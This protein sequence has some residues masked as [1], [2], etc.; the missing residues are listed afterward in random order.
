MSGWGR[1][2]AE[3]PIRVTHPSQCR[4]VHLA[5][6]VRRLHPPVPVDP[7]PLLDLR[8]AGERAQLS[9][10]PGRNSPAACGGC[11]RRA[12]GRAGCGGA[13]ARERAAPFDGG[14]T[15]RARRSSRRRA[16]MARSRLTYAGRASSS[17]G[18]G[19]PERRISACH[20][21]GF[22]SRP[23]CDVR[24]AR[25][26]REKAVVANQGFRGWLILTQRSDLTCLCQ[27]ADGVE[28]GC[29]RGCMTFR[30]TRVTFSVHKRNHVVNCREK[31]R[32]NE[33]LYRL[34]L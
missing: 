11:W 22:S 12:G 3:A 34:K 5:L 32:K 10:R 25:Q 24:D 30:D 8:P 14:R 23:R 7:L 13:C 29:R 17:W 2:H 4:A 27:P 6:Q 16:A 18:P 26:I 31:Y 28:L 20:Q 33:F 19:G 15:S 1:S 9:R 21:I